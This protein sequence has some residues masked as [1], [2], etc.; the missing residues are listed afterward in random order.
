MNFD[1]WTTN[2]GIK[3]PV[4]QLTTQHIIRILNGLDNNIFTLGHIIHT[5]YTQEGDGDG[6]IYDFV[7]E[8]TEYINTWKDILTNELTSRNLENNIYVQ[9]I[10]HNTDI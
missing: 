1:Y 5:G 4:N 9:N 2:T 6:P 8:D 7:E 10:I 3:I